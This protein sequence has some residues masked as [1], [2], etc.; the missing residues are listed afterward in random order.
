MQRQYMNEKETTY[1]EIRCWNKLV[2][3]KLV[4]HILIVFKREVVIE[5]RSYKKSI[6]P[7]IV[8]YNVW[9]VEC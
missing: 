9:F 4:F 1:I 2:S 5:S 6:I 7:G 3:Y 8:R